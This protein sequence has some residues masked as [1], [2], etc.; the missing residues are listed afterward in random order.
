MGD[1]GVLVP[2]TGFDLDPLEL[3]PTVSSLKGFSNAKWH[4]NYSPLNFTSLSKA[5]SLPG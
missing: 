5:S 4:P 3:I 1:S 2:H